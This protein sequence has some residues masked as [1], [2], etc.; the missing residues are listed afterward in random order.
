MLDALFEKVES[1]I[2]AKGRKPLACVAWA[3]MC[4]LA[5]LTAAVG[6]S[7]AP[8]HSTTAAP[9]QAGPAPA[10]PGATNSASTNSS[11]SL[12]L[13]EGDTIKISFPGAPTLDTTQAIR[14]DGK[15][16]LE[17][18]GEYDAVGKTPASVEA[19]LKKLYSSQ[20]VN[21][22][23][24]VTVQS[25]A[26]VIYVMGAVSRPGKLISER[27]LSVLEALI[28]AGIDNSKSNLKSIQILR[29]DADG[30]HK[31]TLNLYK[32]IHKKNEPMPVF[33]L[34]PYDVINV[35]ER[36]SFIQ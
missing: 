22:D 8:P 33:T 21:S 10:S 27:P 36:F 3:A 5:V 19:E 20:I 9:Q 2:C 14:R 31:F 13:Q 11:K 28:E 12:V 7:S 18:I 35:P 1:I 6:C 32:Y 23:V 25:S 29:N 15:I 26:F 34:K 4:S 16:S 24:S 17:M 30:A